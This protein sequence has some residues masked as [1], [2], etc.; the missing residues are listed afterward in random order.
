MA[1]FTKSFIENL[2]IKKKMY[3]VSDDGCRGL[4]VRVLPTGT[5]TYF[6]RVSAYGN[7]KRKTIGDVGNVK[8]SEAREIAAMFL[9]GPNEKK[10]SFR[11]CQRLNLYPSLPS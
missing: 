10:G 9:Q 7:R 4:S 1:K 8:I 11:I 2:E 3:T 5:K 6:A